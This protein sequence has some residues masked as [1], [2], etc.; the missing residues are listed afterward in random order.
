MTTRSWFAAF[1]V[2]T[3]CAA[4]YG[5][6]TDYPTRPVR[7]VTPTSPG[8]SNDIMSRV[9]AQALTAELGNQVI[10]DN[11]GGAGGIIGME[12]VRNAPTDGYTL[13]ATSTTAMSIVPNLRRKLPYDPIEDFEFISL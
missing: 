8:T 10:V 3:F 4:A 1:V 12:I 7:L 2:G 11:R 13:A 6:S 9:V 5:A